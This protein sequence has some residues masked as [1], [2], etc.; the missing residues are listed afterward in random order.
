M[1]AWAACTQLPAEAKSSLYEKRQRRAQS[2][3]SGLDAS[4]QLLAAAP[5]A[6]TQRHVLLHTARV[7]AGMQ[8]A[9][10][11]SRR[12]CQFLQ[13]CSG[14]E[15]AQWDAIQGGLT[16]LFTLIV[17]RLRGALDAPA[18]VGPDGGRAKHRRLLCLGHAS[19]KKQRR[20][21]ILQHQSAFRVWS[22]GA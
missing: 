20:S 14:C 17:E 19:A 3:A 21:A 12:R 22:F 6:T 15:P 11:V 2:R 8:H 5:H 16:R 1:A 10:A 13:G 7:L 4:M 18:G 9:D